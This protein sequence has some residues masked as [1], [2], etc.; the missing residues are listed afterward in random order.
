MY[1]LFRVI[2]VI[3]FFLDGIISSFILYIFFTPFIVA[4]LPNHPV[5]PG[6]SIPPT[7]CLFISNMLTLCLTVFPMF[8]ASYTIGKNKKNGW[9]V[10]LIPSLLWIVELILTGK[11]GWTF[12]L[13]IIKIP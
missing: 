11:H 12:T 9:L 4:S 5:Y 7:F 2:G 6:K 13:P 3:F 10:G 8:I 1:K